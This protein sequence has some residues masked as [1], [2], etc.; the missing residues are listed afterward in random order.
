MRAILR[1]RRLPFDWIIMTKEWREAASSLRPPTLIPVLQYPDGSLQNDTSAMV[2][3]L[4]ARHPERSVIPDED[5]PAFLCHL[6]EDFADE[7]IVKPLFLF[8]WWDSED[9]AY[10]SRWAAEEWSVFEDGM[11]RDQK[12]EH[13][14]QRQISR[15]PILGA[16]RENYAFLDK[17]FRRVLEAC[18]PHTGMTS[19]LFGTRP[20]LAD[21]ALYGQLSQLATDPTPMRIVRE[22]APFTDHWVRRLDDASGVDGEWTTKQVGV[23][24]FALELLKIVGEVYLPFLVENERAVRSGL[25]KLTLSV[26]GLQYTLS[27]FKY[28]VKC[29]Q[30]LRQR[31]SALGNADKSFVDPLLDRTGCLAHLAGV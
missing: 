18:E 8:R 3:A 6:L 11:T 22:I 25:E 2:A 21:F 27:P 20:S 23:T 14:R 12:V 15:M 5:A 7:W 24:Q 29:L 19:Y 16:V 28:Q 31:Y 13:F 30:S 10:V 4:E 17:S 26:W 9:Q 1:Y